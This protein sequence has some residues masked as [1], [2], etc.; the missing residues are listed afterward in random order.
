MIEIPLV[1]LDPSAA[2]PAY[3][4]PGDAGAD[5]VAREDVV[6]AAGGGRAA[7]PTGVAVAIPQG[8]AG[9]VLPRSGLALRHGVTA[10]NA[11]GLVDSGYRGE[12]IV[13]LVNTDPVADYTVRRGDRIAQLVV[14]RVESATFVVGDEL[15][16]SASERGTGGFGHTGR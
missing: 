8:F 10:L 5:L 15:P 6:L 3:A 2:V 7:V 1:R 4:R 11:P 12:L 9:F 13:V 16:G 14:Q